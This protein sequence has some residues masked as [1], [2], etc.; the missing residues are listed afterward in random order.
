[1]EWLGLVLLVFLVLGVG[2]AVRERRTGR[3]K[4]ID[5]RVQDASETEVERDLQRASD[6]FRGDGGM[7]PH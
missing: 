6:A 2:L 1:M 7:P 3:G 5:E 4:I